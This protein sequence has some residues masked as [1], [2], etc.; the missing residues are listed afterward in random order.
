MQDCWSVLIQDQTTTFN[1]STDRFGLITGPLSIR[2][3][4][5]ITDLLNK[6][7]NNDPL[8]LHESFETGSGMSRTKQRLYSSFACPES[9]LEKIPVSERFPGEIL[10]RAVFLQ[11]DFEDPNSKRLKEAIS[12][13]RTALLSHSTEEAENLWES[14]LAI[15]SKL[16]INGGGVDL[17]SLLD[18]LRSRYLLSDHPD[19]SK[20]W[21]TLAEWTDYELRVIRSTIGGKVF[22][23][24]GATIDALVKA[25]TEKRAVVIL[26]VSG[27]GKTVATKSF[28]ENQSQRDLVLWIQASSLD[29][30][31]FTVFESK[32]RLAYPLKDVL[33]TVATQTAYLMLAALDRT[34][35]EAS[36][37]N[38]SMLIEAGCLD[39]AES[40]WK[41]VI[42]CQPEEWARVQ[43][44]LKSANISVE[45]TTLPFECP[46]ASWFSG[47]DTDQLQERLASLLGK[48]W[49]SRN[50]E[51]RRNKVAFDAFKS[52]LKKL[53]AIQN[54]L[55]FE[56]QARRV[57]SQSI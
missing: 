2:V 12:V 13:L 6:A 3:Q 43:G 19:Y 27:S 57:S 45:F 26:G 35:S 8:H 33:R 39:S 46:R 20:D 21:S 36:F 32:F 24:R 10:K 44:Q 5:S 49:T 9:L 55:A 48:V 17:P 42:T 54:S 11:F 14:L 7:E 15:T 28:V 41:L 1:K 22:L 53:I 18:H 51:L 23:P 4:N 34:F 38:L 40:P 56:I 31:N 37:K 52:L 29:C 47:R 30:E 25:L 50:G 16:R